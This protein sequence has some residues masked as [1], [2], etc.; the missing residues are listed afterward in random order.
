MESILNK[1]EEDLNSKVLGI[2]ERRD[3]DTNTSLFQAEQT[4]LDKSAR[5]YQTPLTDYA[6]EL[7][8]SEP[9]IATGVGKDYTDIAKL[10][11][12]IPDRKGAFVNPNVR[13]KQVRERMDD[14]KDLRKSAKDFD[15]FPGKTLEQLNTIATKKYNDDKNYLRRGLYEQFL[16][17]GLNPHTAWGL[18]T[19]SENWTPVFGEAVMAEDARL[20][21]KE[22]TMNGIVAGVMLSG[23]VALGTVPIF[24]DIGSQALKLMSKYIK[25]G[26]VDAK[27]ARELLKTIPF[28]KLPKKHRMI[29]RDE[30]EDIIIFHGTSLQGIKQ[31]N[32]SKV[33][34]DPKAGGVGQGANT[35]GYGL[36]LTD[37]IDI[38]N[39][40][41][42]IA[43]NNQ[44]DK[45]TEQTGGG[46]QALQSAAKTGKLSKG[47]LYQSSLKLH[48][49]ELLFFE[50][51]MAEQGL[52]HLSDK[53]FQYMDI[54]LANPNSGDSM[55][56][57]TNEYTPIVVKPGI[58]ENPKYLGNVGRTSFRLDVAFQRSIKEP[59]V[60]ALLPNIK[61]FTY[62]PKVQKIR[63]NIDKFEALFAVPQSKDRLFWNSSFTDY[64]VSLQKRI[65]INSKSAN[66]AL[67][68]TK[69]DW[70]PDNLKQKLNDVINKAPGRDVSNE[71]ATAFIKEILP[72]IPT[73]EL[74]NVIRNQ[75]LSWN[76]YVN[77][78]KSTNKQ[79]LI[80]GSSRSKEMY[81]EFKLA[82]DS[83]EQLR[84]ASRF[85]L[86]LEQEH[87]VGIKINPV[88]TSKSNPEYHV[89]QYDTDM[90]GEF[91]SATSRKVPTDATVGYRV[92][93]FFDALKRRTYDEDGIWSNSG[94]YQSRKGDSSLVRV[95]PELQQTFETLEEA[96]KVA[97]NVL[98]KIKHGGIMGGDF[99]A[100]LQA[101]YN[102]NK[103]QVAGYL[104]SNGISA[105]KYLSD[106]SRPGGKLDHVEPSYNYVIWNDEAI[107]R[108]IRNDSLLGAFK[109]KTNRAMGVGYGDLSRAEKNIFNPD[110][111]WVKAINWKLL[112][113]KAKALEYK[114][115]VQK[116]MGI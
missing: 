31:L 74:N 82:R 53:E 45:I 18:T 16:S 56:S 14:V 44:M 65:N 43:V 67:Q 95:F 71:N 6:E 5:E 93:M 106:Y 15:Y 100:Y 98:M 34:Q 38:A 24:G 107:N 83:M 66:P 99:Q 90:F 28:H 61:S 77:G 55:W 73:N 91:E 27:K 32:L 26:S 58:E 108:S 113:G 116:M 8:A 80:D 12:E 94:N 10:R 85:I 88:L 35:F 105:M 25:S 76:N 17:Y 84:E 41:R 9:T 11:G 52:K 78:I 50:K 48:T 22:G 42:K 109:D 54:V 72:Y 89:K 114:D 51:D 68:L 40:Y 102:W 87:P 2:M 101:K 39:R 47:E 81:E 110:P 21:F 103:P 59:H 30:L 49:S 33:G 96:Q 29:L 63:N 115:R 3:V 1:E 79:A 92:D 69:V 57:I 13:S 20:S 97:E 60:Q 111:D 7:D 62:T 86:E 70:L 4:T 19:Q 104:S 46:T 37:N 112:Q 75:H 36:Y 64:L 23:G